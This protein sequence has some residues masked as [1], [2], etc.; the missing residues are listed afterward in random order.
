MAVSNLFTSYLV[1][2]ENT[3][4]INLLLSAVST[5]YKV[6]SLNKHLLYALRS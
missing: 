2:Y 3:P 6:G 5:L 4:Q 1:E